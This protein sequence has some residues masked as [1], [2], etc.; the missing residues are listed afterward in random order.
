MDPRFGEP[1]KLPRI[2]FPVRVSSSLQEER[3]ETRIQEIFFRR[4]VG[5][6]RA[7]L[8][9]GGQMRQCPPI[10]ANMVGKAIKS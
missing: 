2:F 5:F 3:F 7:Q 6:G 8:G 9:A 4:L 1:K 10:M